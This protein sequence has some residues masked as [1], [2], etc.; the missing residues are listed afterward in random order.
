MADTLESTGQYLPKDLRITLQPDAVDKDKFTVVA[1]PLK[2]GESYVF[3]FRYVF[4]D[5]STSEW[6]PGYVVL[7]NTETVPSAPTGVTVTG[8][9]GLIKVALS[10]FPTNAKRVDIYVS[11]GAFG[12]GNKVV[13]SFTSAGIKTIVATAGVYNVS[14][15]TVTPSNI[16]GD[17]TG[18]YTVTVTGQQ[19]VI[20]TPTL[21]SGLSVASAPYAVSINWNGTYSG[22]TF[23]GFKSIDIHARDSDVGATATT[24]FSTTTQVATLTVNSTTNRQ[25][26][27]LDNLRQALGLASNTL[28][29]TSP[30][31]FYY[32]SRN[33]NDSLY[34]VGGTPTYTRINS[35]SVNPSKGNYVDL[36]NGVISIENLVAG[37]GQFSSW[38]RTGSVG[39]ARIELS[40]T[41]DFT[42]TGESIVVKKGITAYSTGSTEIFRLDIGTTPKLTIKG[43]GEFT[44]DLSIGSG[45]NIF[46]AKPAEGIWLG[47]TALGTAPFSVTNTGILTAQ[48]GSIGGWTIDGSQLKSTANNNGQIAL[49]PNTGNG[50]KI[51]LI[52]SGT[53]KITIDPV[54]G[55][56]GPTVTKAG[57]TGPA[58]K[59]DTAGNAQFRGDIYADS[60]IFSGTLRTGTSGSYIEITSAR[61]NEITFYSSG[62]KIGRAHV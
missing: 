11:G 23:Q 4:E 54:E 7:T 20:E 33:E 21:P 37:N 36:A 60:G 43:D 31:Y 61:A 12:I 30:I 40:G 25:N 62:G 39:G 29:Y 45:S 15:F 47:S 58:F 35:T 42:P 19:Q 27:G 16:N 51:A 14:L 55:I 46:K 34:S 32:I 3:Q 48:S 13:E 9:V 38:L 56:V 1:T 28:A 22:S 26:V 52:L 24:G 57:N 49:Y 8:D 2:I 50:G 6:G 41:N 44:G 5:G 59:I 17:P 18:V 10:S 53:E